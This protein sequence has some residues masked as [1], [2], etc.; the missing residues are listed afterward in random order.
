MTDIM[1]RT[2]PR[3]PKEPLFPHF[4]PLEMADRSA[5]EAF[6]HQFD[7]YSDF[8]FSTL[9]FYDASGHTRWCWL[10]GNLVLLFNDEFGPG[11]FL[12]FLGSEKRRKPLAF[13]SNMPS[14]I[15]IPRPCGASLKSRFGQSLALP[16]NERRNSQPDS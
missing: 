13:S 2:E 6:T 4:K 5:I 8:C 3:P 11:T 7:P 16:S 1:A 15:T 14:R 9:L 12:T 10:H